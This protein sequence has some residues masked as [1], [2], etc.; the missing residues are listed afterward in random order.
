MTASSKVTVTS[1]WSPVP[2]VVPLARG[3]LAIN[4]EEI[5]AT[6]LTLTVVAMPRLALLLL[7]PSSAVPVSVMTRLSEVLGVWLVFL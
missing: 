4:T 6:E 3:P 2:K 7:A 1:I 5:S